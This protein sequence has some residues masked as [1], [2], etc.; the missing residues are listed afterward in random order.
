MHI[1]KGTLIPRDDG[2]RIEEFIGAVRTRTDSVSIARMLAPVG[3]KEP[4]QVPEFDEAVIVLSGILTVE[5]EG[6]VHS[7]TPG[8]IG[9]AHRGEQVVYRNDQLI[10]CEYWSICVPAFRPSRV[11]MLPAASKAD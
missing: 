4:P 7:V 3:W 11:S 10:P 9:F 2:K 5:T 1:E 6:D 8:T